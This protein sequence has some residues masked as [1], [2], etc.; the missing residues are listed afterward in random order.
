MYLG[1]STASGARTF[2]GIP[3][4]WEDLPIVKE[5]EDEYKTKW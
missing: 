2:M 3:V 4:E 1:G 5:D